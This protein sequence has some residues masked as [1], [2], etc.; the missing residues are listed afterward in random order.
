MTRSYLDFDIAVELYDD[1]TLV[2]RV[3]SSPV[4]EYEVEVEWPFTA[5]DIE[6]LALKAVPVAQVRRVPGRGDVDRVRDFGR[7]LYKTVFA[8]GVGTLLERSLDEAERQQ[9]GLRFRFR[10]GDAEQLASVPWEYLYSDRLN[11][12]LAVSIDTPVVRYLDLPRPIYPLLVAPPLRVLVVMSNPRGTAELNVEGEWARVKAA[13]SDLEKSGQVSLNRLGRATLD[14]LRNALRENEYHVLHFIGHGGFDERAHQGL[15]YFETEDGSDDEVTTEILGT[16][17]HDHRSIRLAVLNSCEGGRRTSIDPFSGM[18][19]GLVTQ[20]LAAVVAMQFEITDRSATRFACQFYEA[21]ADGYPV[22]AAVSEARKSLFTD[23]S[24]VEWGTP[25]L[26]LRSPDGRVFDKFAS[27][28][29]RS[30]VGDP[31]GE[32]QSDVVRQPTTEG[33]EKVA[34]QQPRNSDRREG[35][36][37][38]RRAL[39]AAGSAAAVLGLGGGAWALL[40]GGRSSRLEVAWVFETGGQIFSSPAVHA[41]L[42][43][44]GSNDGSL[45]AI[46]AATGTEVW[47]YRA[48]DAITSSPLIDGGVVYVGSNDGGLHAVNAASG[49]PLW[50]FGTEG[51]IHSSPA[52]ADG[53]VYVGSR[54]HR[55]YAIDAGRGTE[56]WRF[57]GGDWFNSSPTPAR[58]LVL[59]GCRD[60]NIY[61]VDRAS[62]D[63]RWRIAT[64]STVDSS[65]VTSGGSAWIGADD[66]QLYAFRLTGELSWSFRAESG[67]VSSPLFADDTI[68]VGS[69]DGNLYAL[70]ASTGRVQWT[71]A[72]GNGIRSSPIV[73]DGVVYVGSRDRSLYAVD[74]RTGV[75]KARFETGAPIDDSSPAISDGLVYVGS[76]DRSLYALRPRL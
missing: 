34:D 22:D 16:I 37:I 12:F 54:D 33:E 32:A 68:Y 9:K 6:I 57:E 27:D 61:G 40:G 53:L 17:I 26:Y 42:V 38:S 41:A 75:E 4:G 30:I 72:S 58:D 66:H 10:L 39:I 43:Y 46:N 74:Q 25:V 19:S 15:L 64:A 69:D 47:R 73:H 45:Y 11:R 63:E 55:L 28:L 48:E 1:G 70:D 44:V 56:V 29:D 31:D 18:A 35:T 51:V 67:L 13:M 49:Q 8:D 62:G 5:Q 36:T 7:R 50:R 14:E 2:S 23:R 76:L 71:F 59:I 65:A 60:H 20:G 52:A 3:L 24:G 21:M